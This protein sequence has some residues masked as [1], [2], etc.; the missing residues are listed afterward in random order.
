MSPLLYEATIFPSVPISIP[1]K[2][3]TV[4]PSWSS[5]LTSNRLAY[6]VGC[7]F[8]VAASSRQLSS[9]PV[10]G[11][12]APLVSNED[13]PVVAVAGKTNS[14]KVPG[15]AFATPFVVSG[16]PLELKPIV[17]KGVYGAVVCSAPVAGSTTKPSS[18]ACISHSLGFVVGSFFT[19]KYLS[20][21]YK[22]NWK[23]ANLL[24]NGA[25]LPNAKL[26]EQILLDFSNLFLVFRTYITKDYQ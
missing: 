26:I 23:S 15:F 11:N 1:A 6:W 24:I 9:T 22:A 18:V 19:K 10:S 21:K 14:S 12:D 17:V 8:V 13:N 20:G 5:A 16:K 4:A 3:P 7:L 2:R 25:L